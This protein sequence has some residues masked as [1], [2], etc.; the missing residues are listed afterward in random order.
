MKKYLFIVIAIFLVF[1]CKAADTTRIHKKPV[2]HLAGFNIEPGRVLQTHPYVQGE[3]PENKPFTK[4][5]ALTALYGVQ[6]D[7][8]K[9]WQQLYNYPVWGGGL[10]YGNFFDSGELG[11]PFA[12]FMFIDIPFI[13]WERWSIN[14]EVRFGMS[15]GWKSHD[16]F[17]NG[18]QYPL[19]SFSTI[20]GD[21]GIKAVMQVS[22]HIDL[23]A[24]FG[25]THFSNGSVKLPNYGLN[26]IAP[27]I[28]IKYLFEKKPEF[29]KNEKPKYKPEMEWL[30]LFSPSYRQ[31]AFGY[32]DENNDSVAVAFDYKIFNLSSTFNYQITHLVKFG[33]GFDL[34]YNEA[35]GTTAI[36]VDGIPEKGPWQFKDKVLLG[37]YPSFELVINKVSLILQPGFYLYRQ[38]VD[39]G[40]ETPSSYQRI[41]LKYH[42]SDHW[43]AGLNVR[44]FNF[45]K[46]DFIEFNFGYRFK[47]NRK[48]GNKSAG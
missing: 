39:E 11:T 36:I 21:M 40:I 12:L 1:N 34:S 7:G 32:H 29:I 10:F 48:K 47:L 14:G 13:R 35:Y 22:G 42:F 6:T 38:K 28:G 16:P 15:F 19:G 23:S 41:G 9:L 5:L 3:N 17:E 33:A 45:S 46:A 44:A 8:R 4:Y 20:F 30:V 2:S 27:K 43:L 18:F 37:V 31:V 26:M 25:F 24:G